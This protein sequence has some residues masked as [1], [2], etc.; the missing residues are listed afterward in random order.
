MYRNIVT[1]GPQFF[2][3]VHAALVLSRLFSFGMPS[4]GKECTCSPML[5]V[6][7]TWQGPHYETC[8]SSSSVTRDD[9]RCFMQ[10]SVGP[11]RAICASTGGVVGRA[12][13]FALD[14]KGLVA[15]ATVIALLTLHYCR[16]LDFFLPISYLEHRRRYQP[17]P[18]PL[19][20]ITI[21]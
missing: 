7:R 18:A 9:L 19:V 13:T 17:A 6:I 11:Y 3:V 1:C 20:N 8:A 5:P 4:V 16:I 2:C 14:Y 12:R 15:F 10:S 21:V